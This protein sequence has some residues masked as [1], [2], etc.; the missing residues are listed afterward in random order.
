M[1]KRQIVELNKSKKCMLKGIKKI[2]KLEN[3]SHKSSRVNSHYSNDNSHY[4]RL[5]LQA[6]NNLRLVQINHKKNL[7][8]RNFNNKLSDHLVRYSYPQVR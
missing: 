2:V 3:N 1:I 7:V 4:G 5:K 8:I 6:T